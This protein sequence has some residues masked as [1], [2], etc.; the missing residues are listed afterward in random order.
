M[1]KIVTFFGWVLFVLLSLLPLGR[2]ICL[3]SGYVFTLTNASVYMV[4]TAGLSVCLA[5][6][7]I[8]AAFSPG[9]VVKVLVSL[10]TPMSVVNGFFCMIV[11]SDI[12]VVISTL[13]SIGCCLILTVRFGNPSGLTAM[14]LVVAVLLILPMG[15]FGF[16]TLLFG[17]LGQDTVVKTVGSP[18]G[19]YYAQV[20]DSDQGALGGD[21]L[22]DVYENKS[23]DTVIFRVF[24]KP[25]TVYFGDWGEAF[26]MQ[27]HWKNDTCLVI[28][29]TEYE[30]E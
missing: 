11:Y 2:L 30:I 22:V 9:A 21:T 15:C 1:K 27:I 6:L 10:L 5:V 19:A 23:F 12:W 14:G 26:D 20:I 17:N 18:S 25:Q 28:N 8:R 3:R 13:I 7:S 29:G 4:V 16:L 24:K